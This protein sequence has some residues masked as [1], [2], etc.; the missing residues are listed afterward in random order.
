MKFAIT[1]ALI[2][3]AVATLEHDSSAHASPARKIP[4]DLK[5][6]TSSDWSGVP[7]LIIKAELPRANIFQYSARVKYMDKEGMLRCN[8]VGLQKERMVR[9]AG[10]LSEGKNRPGLAFISADS[11]P[12]IENTTMVN[13][14]HCTLTTWP[15]SVS[16]KE[17]VQDMTPA[18]KDKVLPAIF[19]QVISAFRYLESMG[20]IY[21]TIGPESIMICSNLVNEVPNVIVADLHYIWGRYGYS[22]TEDYITLW[23]GSDPENF[24]NERGYR[25]PED[26][27]PLEVIFMEKRISW[28]LGA[29]IYGTLAGMPPYGFTKT[30][31]GIVP[32]ESGRLKKVMKDLQTF[33]NSTYPPVE[34]SNDHL[35]ALMNILLNRDPQARP[36]IKDL[37]LDLIKK[38]ADGSNIKLMPEA[39]RVT[40]WG[41]LSGLMTVEQQPNAPMMPLDEME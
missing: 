4:Q 13:G 19:V 22:R 2:A 33:G 25:A 31:D 23:Q 29:T 7:G 28:M 35:A 38:L 30:L 15:E 20:F 9:I 1:A 37:D 5:P 26:Y 8:V 3:T 39:S 12:K 14:Q 32:W 40:L 6:I 24:E 10:H 41:L 36:A 27:G 21:D 11:F 16:L 34:T 18:Q 17:Y